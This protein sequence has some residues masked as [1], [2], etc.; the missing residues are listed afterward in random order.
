MSSNVGGTGPNGDTLQE[1]GSTSTGDMASV[2]LTVVRPGATFISEFFQSG[3]AGFSTTVQDVYTFSILSNGVYQFTASEA[4]Y[5]FLAGT[6]NET[7]EGTNGIPGGPTYTV[8]E[9][10]TLTYNARV[11]G[12]T[13]IPGGTHVIKMDII[14]ARDPGQPCF[15][16]G[17]E[18]MTPTGPVAVEDLKVDDLIITQDNGVQPIRWIG[19]VTVGT[20]SKRGL[21]RKAPIRI[22]AGALG[23]GI[24]K[25]DVLVSP[26]HRML[27]GNATT[28]L[29]F[30]QSEVLVPAKYLVNGNS[31]QVADD[32]KEVEYFHLLFDQ[33]E[34]VFAEG[35]PSESFHPGHQGLGAFAKD[36][37][38]E[39]IE[40]FPELDIDEAMYGPAARLS[41]KRHEGEAL[42]RRMFGPLPS[43]NTSPPSAISA[44]A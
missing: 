7:R 1:S 26:Q 3:W 12:G 30:E 36:T 9:S 38:D 14:G 4:G 17:T 10:F 15:A 5:D 24:P 41:L 37:R 21:R 31:I 40:L 18:L 29:M 39:I 44:R 33:H 19:S 8:T 25:R 23:P 42:A 28:R 20:R 35:A 22:A 11:D 27:V 6:N 13:T 16:R 43:P 2:T 32:L 34:V